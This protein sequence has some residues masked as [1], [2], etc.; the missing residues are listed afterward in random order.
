VG[1]HTS[2]LALIE[3]RFFSLGNGD[4]ERPHLT[5]RDLHADTL[6]DLFDFNGSPSLNTPVGVALPPA[7]D[8]TP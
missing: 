3:K 8:C 2:L 4:T 7:V 6:E 1:D 5:L